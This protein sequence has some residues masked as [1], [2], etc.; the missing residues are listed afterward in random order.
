MKNSADYRVFYFEDKKKSTHFVLISAPAKALLARRGQFD[1]LSAATRYALF[2]CEII[3][4]ERYNGKILLII[5]IEF[6]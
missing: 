1:M 4:G 5:F 2:E 3:K 6:R